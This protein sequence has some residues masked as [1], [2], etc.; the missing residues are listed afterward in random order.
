MRFLAQL[1]MWALMLLAR[2]TAASCLDAELRDHLERQT[3]ENIAAGMSADDARYAALREFGNLALLR[4]QTRA[5][6]SWSQ[7]EGLLRDVRYGVRTLAR[8]PAFTSIAMVVMALGIGANVAMFT[9]IRSVLLK[10]LPYPDPDRLMMVY[11]RDVVGD[12]DSMFNVVAGGMYAEWKQQNQTFQNLGLAGGFE[13]NVSGAGGQL[14]EKLHGVNCTWNLLPLLGVKAALGRSFTADDDRW[15]ANGTVMLTW[16]LWKRRFGGDPGILNQ[17]VQINRRACTVIGVLPA[18]FVFPEDPAVQLLTPVYHEKPAERMASR[19]NHQFVVIGR[20]HPGVTAEQASTDLALIARRLHDAHLDEPIIGKSAVTRPLLDD[21]VVDARRPLYMLFAATGC[22]LLIVCLNVANLLVAR[23]AALRREHAIRMA[24]GG[25]GMRLLRAQLMESFLL[26]SGGGAAGLA[27]AWAAIGWLA[28]ARPDLSRVE[29][30]HIDVPVVAFAVGLICLCALVAG[31]IGSRASRGEHMLTSLQES[32]RGSTMA[33]GRVRLRKALMTLEVALT[34][35]LL[36][37]AGLLL[38]SYQR[39][40][41]SDMGCTTSNV[42]T[43]RIALFGGR[44]GDRGERVNFFSDFLQKVRALP[45]VQAAGFVQAVPGQGFWGDGPF[46]IVEHP[47][48]SVG[49]TDMAIYRWADPGYFAA[50]GIPVLRGRT[51]D[52]GKRLDK[53]NE[54]VISKKFADRKLPGE[55]PIGKHVRVDDRVL[56]IVGVVGDTRFAQSEE[57]APMQYLPLYSGFPNHGS[58]VIR[59]SQDVDKFAL[60]VEKLLQSI[61]RDLPV[62]DVMTMDQLLGK[63]AMNVSFDATLLAVF[64]GL[65]LLLAAGFFGVLSF[66]VAQ[67]T[68]EI[69]IRMALGA[70]R[71]QVLL[72]ILLDGLRPALVGLVLGLAASVATARGMQSMLYGTQS[73][74][75]FV[76]AGVSAALLLAAVAACVVPA[77]RASRLDPMQALRT[78]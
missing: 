14:P 66:L 48:L 77:W 29:A 44:F 2:G 65:S 61:D 73:M 34:V 9:V 70:R 19:G 37:G 46:S 5:R 12:P 50:M 40:R 20:L 58:L 30:V 68:G 35:V 52:D 7:L 56:T 22:M 13:S 10:P 55:N 1:R 23:G 17:T 57:P 18:W 38:K 54:I 78:E 63:S 74:D 21:M 72:R 59:S 49:Q 76:F 27:L 32:G 28:K 43:M 36:V 25:G 15:A 41:S 39:L 51:F 4:D 3:A 75:G 6:W 8:A 60:P 31:V 42:L 11:E 26:C 53:A 71:E 33:H 16:G 64:A 62:S 69:G 24:L 67:R 45:G 47:S